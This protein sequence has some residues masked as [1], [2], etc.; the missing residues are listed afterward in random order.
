MTRSKRLAGPAVLLAG[1]C[2]GL[3]ACAD[4]GYG[5]DGYLAYGAYPDDGF[6]DDGF[7]GGDFDHRH[8]CRCRRQIG[9]AATALSA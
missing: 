3:A 9:P 5:N 4:G 7:H 8:D 6:Y 1:L 2:L